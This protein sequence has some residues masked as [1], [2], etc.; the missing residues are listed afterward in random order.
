[1]VAR[2][3]LLPL[4]H[5][6]STCGAAW[7]LATTLRTSGLW[8]GCCWS[9]PE[10]SQSLHGELRWQR[11]HLTQR[12]VG[13]LLPSLHAKLPLTNAVPCPR[14]PPCRVWDND[15][16]FLLIEAAYGLPRWLKPETAQNR[17]WLHAGTVHLVPLPRFA[18][19]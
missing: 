15:G 19:G 17:L 3:P 12:L 16:E 11:P 10:P 14:L 4:C 7:T 2:Q 6:R 5:Q 1:M 18:G 13:L 8:C 9:S